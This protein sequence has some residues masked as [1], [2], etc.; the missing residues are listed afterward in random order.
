[1]ITFLQFE[2]PEDLKRAKS[3]G[4]YFDHS[5]RM[6]YTNDIASFRKLDQYYKDNGYK[7]YATKEKPKKLM[8]YEK[9]YKKPAK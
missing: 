9:G 7:Q 2:T 8:S 4:I 5:V 6:W 3:I 1:M